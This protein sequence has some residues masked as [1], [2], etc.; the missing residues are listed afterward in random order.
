MLNKFVQVEFKSTYLGIKRASEVEATIS[1]KRS[2]SIS[3]LAFL[4][5]L[6]PCHSL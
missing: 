1:F 3:D 5:S 6:N 2:L 4:A